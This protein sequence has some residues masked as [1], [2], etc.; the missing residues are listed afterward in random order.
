MSI[1]KYYYSKHY[2]TLFESWIELDNVWLELV[3]F[4]IVNI[5]LSLIF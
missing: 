3:K 1:L 2:K 5:I 4:W